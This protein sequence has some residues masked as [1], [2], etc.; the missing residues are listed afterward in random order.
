MIKLL[1]FA[2]HRG[3]PGTNMALGYVLAV[4]VYQAL[5][6]WGKGNKYVGWLVETGGK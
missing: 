1:H 3:L 6:R 4:A 5:A 2:D